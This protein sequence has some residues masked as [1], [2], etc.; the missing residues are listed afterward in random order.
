MEKTH[1]FFICEEK[2]VKN[3]EGLIIFLAKQINAELVCP[4]CENSK[5]KGF[6]DPEGVKKHMI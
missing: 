5:T 6:V 2:Y 3:L 1:G 4:Y